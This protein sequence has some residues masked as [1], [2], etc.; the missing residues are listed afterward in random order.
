MY[1]EAVQLYIYIFVCEIISNIY[2]SNIYI[3]LYNFIL[4]IIFRFIQAR[5]SFVLI[6]NIRRVYRASNEERNRF[7]L[8]IADIRKKCMNATYMQII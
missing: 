4:C 8:C 7:I 1:V 5:A 3:L 2:I 6:E